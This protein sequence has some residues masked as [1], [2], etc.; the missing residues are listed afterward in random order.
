MS[1]TKESP[2]VLEASTAA[3]S[4]AEIAERYRTLYQDYVA[5]IGQA[6][7]LVVGA[8]G[9]GKSSLCNL[10]LGREVAEVGGGRPVTTAVTPLQVGDLRLYDTPGYETGEDKQRRFNADIKTLLTRL[11]DEGEP[12]DVV[13]Y[14]VNAPVARFTALD[15]SLVEMFERLHKPVAIVLTQVDEASENGCK[16]LGEAIHAALPPQGDG[17]ERCFIFESSTDERLQ[18]NPGLEQLNS[19]TVE[20]LDESRRL[21]FMAASRRG[22]ERKLTEGE[23]IVRQTVA[24]AFLVGFTPIPMSDAALLT[25]AQLSMLA[26]LSYVWDLKSLKELAGGV[27]VNLI[28]QNVGKSLAGNLAKLIPGLGTLTGGLINGSVASA[29]TY[30]LGAAYNRVCEQLCLRGLQGQTQS[31]NELF[32]ERFKAMV[33]QLFEEYQKDDKPGR[34][35]QDRS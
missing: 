27:L 17:K 19:W 34:H 5:Q 2:D 9:A 31:I 32:G 24:G 14:C 3:D 21:S 35:P 26:R 15:A 4:E 25:S 16:E 11:E 8:A 20:M 28:A 10:V 23:S 1:D 7:I 22:I 12:I 29:M 6:S 18:L 30:A 33:A 13:W